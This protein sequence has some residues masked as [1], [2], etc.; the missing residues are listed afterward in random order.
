MDEKHSTVHKALSLLDFFEFRHGKIGLSELA[1]LSGFNKATTQR[2]LS[3]LQDKGFVEQDDATRAYSLG[4]AFLR[5]AELREATV[6]F[7]ETV[8][9]VLRELSAASGETAHVSMLSGG[10]LDNI[11]TVESKQANRVM[12][13]PGERLPLHA[14]ASG[15]VCLA[16]STEAQIDAALAGDLP[17]IE[18]STLTDAD[19][20][21]DVLEGIRKQKICKSA[22]TFETGVTGYATPFFRSDSKISGAV[23]VAMP[24]TRVAADKE[25]QLI[26]HLRVAARRL[27]AACGG[28][29][30][31]PE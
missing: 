2:F 8:Q 14:T 18:S 13:E 28:S 20:I 15:L 17:A 25:A 31:T 10:S 12:I 21:R 29:P 19:A 30:E 9:S 1:K 24:S 27:T 7:R 6:P 26:E 11:G 16:F 4:P 22:D 5:F 23:A 3:A